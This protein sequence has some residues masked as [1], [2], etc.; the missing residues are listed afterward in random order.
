MRRDL[1]TAP[2]AIANYKRNFKILRTAERCECSLHTGPNDWLFIWMEIIVGIIGL[3]NFGPI[4]TVE[5]GIFD[6]W[7]EGRNHRVPLRQGLIEKSI[8]LLPHILYKAVIQFLTYSSSH[9]FLGISPFVRV[10]GH[11]WNAFIILKLIRLGCRCSDTVD[12][13]SGLSLK[14]GLM[15]NFRIKLGYARN[16]C[17]SFSGASF[18]VHA[19]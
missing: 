9:V 16:N 13:I 11:R 15:E 2:G 8:V 6:E 10:I 1:V 12:R 3:V 4:T 14:T 7:E 19:H 5:C 18:M 17:S